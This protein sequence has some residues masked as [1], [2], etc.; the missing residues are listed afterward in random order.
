MSRLSLLCPLH[1]ALFSL[2]LGPVVLTSLSAAADD[3][4]GQLGV[5]TSGQ[6]GYHTYRIPAVVLTTKNTL[7]AFCDGRKTG[8]GDHGD[9][10]HGMAKL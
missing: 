8:R 9:I 2:A 7:L 3:G 4:P 1:F 5:F 10:D 6:Q